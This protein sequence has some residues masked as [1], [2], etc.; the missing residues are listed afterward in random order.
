MLPFLSV[1]SHRRAWA[2][3]LLL[4]VGVLAGSVF[5][6]VR[7][8][9]AADTSTDDAN[10]VNIL[11]GLADSAM[12]DGRLVAP[13]GSNAYEFY[14]SVLQ[15]EPHNEVALENLK[16]AFVPACNEVERLINPT[17]LDEAQRELSLLREYD[18]TNYTLALLGGKLSAQRMLVTRQHEAQ[19]A[20]IQAQQEAA[21]TH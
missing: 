18:P 4:V 1:A 21:G 9:A 7:S 11:L 20:L 10:G 13:E 6:Y 19:A 12:H 17:D 16:K 15:L 3:G 2:I 8:A 14:F 5:W